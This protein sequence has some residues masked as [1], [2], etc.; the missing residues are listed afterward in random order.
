M[1]VYATLVDG[2][3]IER[4][5]FHR[6]PRTRV[7][8]WY[9]MWTHAAEWSWLWVTVIPRCSYEVSQLILVIWGEKHGK[10]VPLLN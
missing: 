7:S 9:G 3:S 1:L 4:L 10:Y 5:Y 8:T 2:H 6:K